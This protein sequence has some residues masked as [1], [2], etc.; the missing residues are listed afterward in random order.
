M[1]EQVTPNERAAWREEAR[2]LRLNANVWRSRLL[3]ALD[4]LD[5]MERA[6]NE[7]AGD[8]H[9]FGVKHIDCAECRALA[10]SILSVFKRAEV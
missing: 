6:Y 4:S 10:D 8:E 7:L 9:T 2:G 3:R 5:L 1:A